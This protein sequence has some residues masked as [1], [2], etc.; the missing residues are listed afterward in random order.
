[1]VK[2]KKEKSNNIEKNA[3]D[4][5]EGFDGIRKTNSRII[6]GILLGFIILD[7]VYECLDV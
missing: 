4:V 2:L 6:F 5:K 1:M 3:L 7:F